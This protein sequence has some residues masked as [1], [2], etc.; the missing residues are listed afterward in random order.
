MVFYIWIIAIFAVGLIFT[1]LNTKSE[2][3]KFTIGGGV[4]V[5]LSK[6]FSNAIA[7]LEVYYKIPLLVTLAIV[8]FGLT[9]YSFL[10]SVA[11]SI[12]TLFA[13]A[14]GLR[15]KIDAQYDNII[16]PKLKAV[17]SQ[18]QIIL[19]TIA[20]CFLIVMIFGL[21]LDIFKIVSFLFLL[22]YLYVIFV[23]SVKFWID[24][25]LI[26]LLNPSYLLNEYGRKSGLVS[27]MQYMVSALFLV[28]P[29]RTIPDIALSFFNNAQGIVKSQYIEKVI[30]SDA[31]YKMEDFL[32]K[33]KGD[34]VPSI[35]DFTRKLLNET[36]GSRIMGFLK[37]KPVSFQS[38]KIFLLHS[39]FWIILIGVFMGL[40]IPMY[41]YNKLL[42]RGRPLAKIIKASIISIISGLAIEY[43]PALLFDYP[44]TPL[45][46][47]SFT[48]LVIFTTVLVWIYEK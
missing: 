25:H 47:T 33:T 32:H 26:K 34:S 1:F 31:F 45:R 44:I 23:N 48:S 16:T 21:Q 14:V 39:Y 20:L 43:I 46:I 6:N 35:A 36:P 9:I 27:L 38:F 15:K 4:P 5:N 13:R 12:V 11:M 28:L 2:V 10:Y 17:Y 18:S 22:L 41:L 40:V 30:K 8:L 3:Y 19:L 7:W 29:V 37:I 42:P 24:W